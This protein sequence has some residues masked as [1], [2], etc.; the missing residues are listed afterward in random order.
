MRMG[1]VRGP[2]HLAARAS[3]AP[4][5]CLKGLPLRLALHRSGLRRQVGPR[6]TSSPG[7]DSK[8]SLGMGVCGCGGRLS[9]SVSA[10]HVASLPG[11]SSAA[12]RIWRARDSS[13]SR[14]LAHAS[15]RLRFA[16]A[17]ASCRTNSDVSCPIRPPT[18]TP[19]TDGPPR[20]AR[21]G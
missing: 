12:V 5:T 3:D 2:A 9:G 17:S 4:P 10:R 14:T 7:R 15:A 19:S 6:R 16:T 13:P 11:A 20:R 21:A 1:R 18:S 8:G